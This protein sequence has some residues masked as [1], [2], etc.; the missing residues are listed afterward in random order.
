MLD[1]GLVLKHSKTDRFSDRGLPSIWG[2]DLGLGDDHRRRLQNLDGQAND[3]AFAEFVPRVVLDEDFH[4]IVD[5]DE[6]AV[7]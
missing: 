2:L 3:L 7:D 4:Q 6:F 1:Y 5:F